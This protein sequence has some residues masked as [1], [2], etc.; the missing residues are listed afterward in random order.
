V[1]SDGFIGAAEEP[2]NPG[3]N[4]QATDSSVLAGLK[5]WG[6]H[7][8]LPSLHR[9]LSVAKALQVNLVHEIKPHW[10]PDPVTGMPTNKPADD[11]DIT[12]ARAC[13]ALVREFDLLDRTWFITFSKTVGRAL[14]SQARTLGIAIQVAYL[15]SD[16]SPK[17][18]YKEGWTGLDY[19][20]AVFMAQSPLSALAE[21]GLKSP[22]AK[23]VADAHA[24]GMNVNTWTVD[25]PTQ[26][27]A[28]T[29]LGVDV[30]TTTHPEIAIDD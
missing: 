25:T 14:L 15:G 9:Y 4:V 5:L 6:G 11:R 21:W 19:H 2:L 16:T 7:E 28:M 3:I 10:I 1:V 17:T 20:Y 23:W 13:L 26:R 27:A 22:Q 29:A 24:L 30:I 12:A 8:T 18:L